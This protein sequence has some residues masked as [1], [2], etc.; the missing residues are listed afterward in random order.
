[1]LIN[2]ETDREAV[3]KIEG[4]AHIIIS[5]DAHGKA[6]LSGFFMGRYDSTYGGMDDDRL[7]KRELPKLL[8]ELRQQ[9]Q[10]QRLSGS[11]VTE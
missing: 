11:T 9:L 2:I 1:M 8:A 3:T 4:K 10:I 6:S 7:Q 5:L